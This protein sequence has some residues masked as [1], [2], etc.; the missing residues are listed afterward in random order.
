MSETRVEFKTI[1]KH[2]LPDY[3]RDEFPLLGEF[4]SQY[5]LSQEF[6]G[7][8]VDLIQN[9]DRYIK[10]NTNATTINSTR[11]RTDVTDSAST[12]SVDSTAGFPDQYGLLRIEMK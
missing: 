6:Q 5:Y 4:L 10:L 12:I 11:L 1:V 3:V 2:Q 8:P 7:A 9:I